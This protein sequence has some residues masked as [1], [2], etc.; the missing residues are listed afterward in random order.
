MTKKILGALVALVLSAGALVGLSASPSSAEVGW[1]GYV[2][3]NVKDMTNHI[4]SSDQINIK[5][6]FYGVAHWHTEGTVC[7]R[8]DGS[9]QSYIITRSWYTITTSNGPEE[10]Y[11]LEGT[12]HGSVQ[13]VLVDAGPLGGD[14]Y[15]INTPPW[16]WQAPGGTHYG[17]GFWS[18][19][20]WDENAKVLPGEAF[21]LHVH[22]ARELTGDWD[23]TWTLHY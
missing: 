1:G 6:A 15:P 11:S 23:Y 22:I 19:G 5:G 14:N 16:T 3:P 21:T 2:C 7:K 13:S 17:D 10:N 4:R 18:S 8:P 9:I 12:G 20:G